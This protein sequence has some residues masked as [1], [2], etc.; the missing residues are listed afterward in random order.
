MGLKNVLPKCYRCLQKKIV[1]EHKS[2][3]LCGLNDWESVSEATEQDILDYI[4][5]GL[6]VVLV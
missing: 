1:E 5:V 4:E 3:K 2:V 6:S